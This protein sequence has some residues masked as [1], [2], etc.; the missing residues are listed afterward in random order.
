M[1]PLAVPPILLRASGPNRRSFAHPS[2][3]IAVGGAAAHRIGGSRVRHF[4]WRLRVREL[5]WWR[6]GRKC[7]QGSSGSSPIRSCF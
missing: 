6:G 1:Q 2:W 3:R 7:P 5:I 4:G